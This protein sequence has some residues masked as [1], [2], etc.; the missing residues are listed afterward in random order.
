ME[1]GSKGWREGVREGG[2][3]ER[4]EE[5]DGVRKESEGRGRREEQIGN[6]CTYTY[7]SS[8]IVMWCTYFLTG[9]NTTYM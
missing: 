1:R 6:A 2:R 3:E 7:L 9:R 8:K 5:R 4:R